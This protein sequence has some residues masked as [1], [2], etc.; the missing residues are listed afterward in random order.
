MNAIIVGAMLFGLLIVIVSLEEKLPSIKD[1]IFLNG[2]KNFIT[3]VM[4]L[5]VPIA[6]VSAFV[7]WANQPSGYEV[8]MQGMNGQTDD[9]AI[10]WME[11]Y[12]YSNR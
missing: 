2:L 9:E 7:E 8:C 6:I 10:A 12:C 11:E 5:C 3:V 1:T 4:L